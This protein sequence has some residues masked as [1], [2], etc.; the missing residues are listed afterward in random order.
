[1]RTVQK[2]YD[3][4]NHA[5]GYSVAEG[6]DLWE[7][8]NSAGQALFS[9]RRWSWT[10]SI[11]TPILAVS[12][13]GWCELPAD[14]DGVGEFIAADGS[15]VQMVDQA[16]IE[17]AYQRA[18]LVNPGAGWCVCVGGY[19]QS[20]QGTGTPRR[21]LGI[22]PLPSFSGL[23]FTAIYRRRWRPVSSLDPNV[24][25]NIPPELEW[26]LICKGRAIACQ[27]EGLG[28]GAD[29]DAFEKEVERAWL[30]DSARTINA[31]RIVGGADRF[32][33]RPID[34]G[35]VATEITRTQ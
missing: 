12:G 32:S 6:H 25:P 5:V 2:I 14:F 23:I 29:S 3:L 31:G 22:W 16:W 19:E 4:L 11:P 7:D 24:E 20:P 17:A 33:T 10:K 13:Q 21:R 26:A 35:T 9:A 34:R 15:T 27:L 30:Q 1:M 28:F 8:I 18:S